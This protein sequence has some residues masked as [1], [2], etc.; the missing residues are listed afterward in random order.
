MRYP[1]LIAIVSHRPVTVWSSQSFQNETVISARPSSRRSSPPSASSVV[2]YRACLRSCVLRV[3]HRSNR[4]T[5]IVASLVAVVVVV[6]VLVTLVVVVV[7]IMSSL[8][9]LSSQRR[10]PGHPP[11]LHRFDLCGPLLPSSRPL[12]CDGS[13]RFQQLLVTTT[14]D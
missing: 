9:Y 3:V 13:S 6:L 7:V 11:A 4:I 5:S 8:S 2:V 12:R 1:R 10:S 14:P